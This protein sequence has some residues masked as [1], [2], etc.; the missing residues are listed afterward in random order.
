MARVRVSGAHRNSVY[1]PARLELES[2]LLPWNS[3]CVEVE[4]YGSVIRSELACS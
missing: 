3:T 1:H 4:A 2:Q